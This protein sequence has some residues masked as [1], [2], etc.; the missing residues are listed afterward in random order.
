MS[1]IIIT[2]ENLSRFS[3]RLQKSI[4]KNLN[5]KIS[6]NDAMT[7][8]SQSLGKSN[9]HEMQLALQTNSNRI[10]SKIMHLSNV[11]EENQ[12]FQERAEKLIES[13]LNKIK[14]YLNQ[15]KK[16][17]IKD[18]LFI[19]RN[20]ELWLSFSHKKSGKRFTVNLTDKE[21]H[22]SSLLSQEDEFKKEDFKN[23]F[24]FYDF[25]NNN[26]VLTPFFISY[27]KNKIKEQH[28]E[29]NSS[30]KQRE[31]ILILSNDPAEHLQK[32]YDIIF[33]KKLLIVPNHLEVNGPYIF[34]EEKYFLI[35][36]Q[37]ME[38]FLKC[39]SYFINYNKE[40]KKIKQSLISIQPCYV[41]I[42]K[43]NKGRTQTIC[44]TNE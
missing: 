27:I 9:I 38:Y 17:Y 13:E 15:N 20:D 42:T 39:G 21:H 32:I 37:T 31:K 12:E 1:D 3:K 41:S 19:E 5:I 44:E 25:L 18:F 8:F 11:K 2:S 34:F 23:L 6:F 30:N 40:F 29:Q 24:Q 10:D 36:H 33:E 28:T 14:I 43:D 22:F 7:M 16:T 35:E 4:E 26:F